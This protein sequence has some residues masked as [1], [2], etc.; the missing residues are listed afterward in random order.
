M[1]NCD[2]LLAKA[3]RSPHNFAFTDICELAECFGW[4]LRRQHG[5]HLIY[6]NVKLEVGQGR[7]QN[8]QNVKGKAKPYQVRQLLKAIEVIEA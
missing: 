4:Q 3:G 6:E 5:S 8:F 7:L 1:A 2:K